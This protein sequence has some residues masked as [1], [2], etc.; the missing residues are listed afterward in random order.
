MKQFYLLQGFNKKRLSELLQ[1]EES[2]VAINS[3]LVF[4]R[5]A[6]EKIIKFSDRQAYVVCNGR[7]GVFAQL[8]FTFV[9]L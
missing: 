1:N 6:M 9:R 5:N 4:Y 8:Q 2:K 7:V 3:K